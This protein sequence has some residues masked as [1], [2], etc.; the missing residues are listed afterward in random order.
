M[1]PADFNAYL[2][3]I[4][5]G[6]FIVNIFLWLATKKSADAAALNAKTLIGL[7][8][9]HL[10][11]YHLDFGDMGVAHIAAKLQYPKIKISIKNYGRTPAFLTEK[12]VDFIFKEKLPDVPPYQQ[13]VLLSPATVIQH[14][15]IYDL[16]E[17]PLDNDFW[18]RFDINSSS[19]ISDWQSLMN[20]LLRERKQFWVYGY[21][22]YKDFSD[23]SHR[24]SFCKQFALENISS[25]S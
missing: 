23:K 7:E 20:D 17:R 9:P 3:L 22:A 4:E 6:L 18:T 21:V 14:D 5:G 1:R 2:V 15:E 16:I 8:S 25:D 24:I 19:T 13:T 10:R 12:S 11:L